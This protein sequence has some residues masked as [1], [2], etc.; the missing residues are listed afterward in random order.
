MAG[1]AK[2]S[3]AASVEA[4]LLA[5]GAASGFEQVISVL[6]F[7]NSSKAFRMESAGA[8]PSVWSAWVDPAWFELDCD[9]AAGAAMH[10]GCALGTVH[11][12]ALLL[13]AD[14]SQCDQEARGAYKE[15]LNQSASTLAA[16]LGGRLGQPVNFSAA[17]ESKAPGEFGMGLGFRFELGGAKH[18]LALVPNST[19]VAALL[20]ID[21]DESQDSPGTD[22]T[23]KS[24]S[25]AESRN[26]PTDLRGPASGEKDNSERDNFDLLLEIE[27]Q[28]GVSF[29]RSHLP[30]EEVLKLSSGAIVEL[31]RLVSDP[32]DVLVNDAVIARGE[33]VVVEGNYGVRITEIVSRRERIRS[34]F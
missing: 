8:Q 16:A 23:E 19:L 9:L 30:L 21:G 11:A 26:T 13:S 2:E 14:D 1:G 20:G 12:L 6:N 3:W 15:I 17:A 27:M 4:R 34:I 22:A 10:V 7:S 24:D 29:G 5:E 28:F 33:V 31:N 25:N 18:A 32:V